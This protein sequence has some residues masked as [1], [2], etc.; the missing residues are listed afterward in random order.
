MK[1]GVWWLIGIGLLVSAFVAGVVS[2]YASSSPDGLER[3]AEDQGFLDQA[4]A[5]V[6]GGLPT[7]DYAI[8]GVENERL[9]VGLA[10]ILGVLVM[11]VV[12]FGLFWFLARG[13]K[14][15]DNTDAKPNVV[16]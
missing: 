8:A 4:T 6:N 5:P 14:S 16:A 1:R 9:S 12:A 2:F 3:V 10:G 7:A 15:A 13:K 11:A